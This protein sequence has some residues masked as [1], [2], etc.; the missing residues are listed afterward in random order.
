MAPRGRQQ[1]ASPH[2]QKSNRSCDGVEHGRLDGLERLGARRER[3]A[4]LA[5][6]RARPRPGRSGTRVSSGVPRSSDDALA[7][8]RRRAPR[9][10]RC[11]LVDD[12]V[13]EP[14]V[15]A[16]RRPPAR[17]LRGTPRW[18]PRPGGTRARRRRR[19]AARRA[20]CRRRRRCARVQ[21]GREQ[22]E[23]VEHQRAERL[24]VLGEVV[25][26]RRVGA[27]RRAVADRRAVE[28]GR[29]LDLERELDRGEQR[30]EAG[31]RRVAAG[32]GDE[33]QRVR[34]EVAASSRCGRAA[35]SP[36]RR[37]PPSA[38]RPRR[39]AA[40]SPAAPTRPRRRDALAAVDH[41]V[42]R[43]R[44]RPGRAA[45]ARRAC[46]G[47]APRRR[48]GV[49]DLDV[50][51]PVEDA[52]LLD[53]PQAALVAAGVPHGALLENAA[54]ARS[55][56]RS[57]TYVTTDR[58]ARPRPARPRR[59]STAIRWPSSCWSAPWTRCCVAA[60][61]SGPPGSKTSASRP[62][63]KSGRIT[64]SPGAVKS[65]CSIRSRRWSSAPVPAVRPRPS[66]W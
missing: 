32:A 14:R 35:R 37:G 8:R 45:A 44:A 11:A 55:C 42:R 34:R 22:A 56:V 25:D 36:G 41:D 63:P 38:R 61:S 17:G 4:V 23:P 43:R 6:R 59:D 46:A 12:V 3:V 26:R 15:P 20:R 50:L 40:A 7:A 62:L 16:Q 39:R 21:S 58:R 28:V 60:T 33:A 30:V 2:V 29:A 19:R 53:R 1:P 18:R 57:T 49:G 54:D 47:A 48:L 5:A 51:D 27:L 24:V 13:D 9:R 64:R 66:T 65:T 10:G 31:R 52:G